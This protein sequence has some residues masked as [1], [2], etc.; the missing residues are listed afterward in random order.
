MDIIEEDLDNKKLFDLPLLKRL[1]K[2]SLP[3]LSLMILALVILSLIMALELI[4]PIVIGKTI[5]KFISG[6][7]DTLA[8]FDTKQPDSIL[9]NNMYYLKDNN[10]YSDKLKAK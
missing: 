7:A 6:Y 8:I 4:K 9:F 2:Y 1:F 3:Y 5:D 10:N